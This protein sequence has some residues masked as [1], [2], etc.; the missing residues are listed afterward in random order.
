MKHRLG[1]TLVVLAVAGMGRMLL[2]TSGATALQS[3]DC[4]ER[5]RFGSCAVE[6]PVPVSSE[7]PAEPESDARPNGQPGGRPPPCTWRTVDGPGAAETLHALFPEAPSDAVLQGRDCANATP[8]DPGGTDFSLGVRWVPAGA[9]PPPAAA[10]P[11]PSDVALTLYA[12]VEALMEAP[13]VATDPPAGTPAL[14][15]LPVFLQVTNWQGPLSVDDC[16]LGVCVALAAT[17][18]LEWWS[19][20]PGVALVTCDGPGVRFDLGGPDPAEQAGWPG[21]CT[22]TYRMRTGSDGRPGLWPG[23]VTV[24]W[25]V[26]WTSSGGTTGAFPPLSLSTSVPQVVREAQSIVSDHE[27]GGV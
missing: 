4:V 5:D 21:A 2:P 20:E 19:G 3:A 1:W 26:S 7:T 6:V 16:V 12:R 15:S 25:A 14:V 27:L 18:S 10:P 11:V 13:V 22:Q 9:A 24:T 17:P 8:R 23:E